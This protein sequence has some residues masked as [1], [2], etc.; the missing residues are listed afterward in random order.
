MLVLSNGENINPEELEAY[1]G[2]NPFVKEIAVLTVRDS[3][4][5][6][7]LTRLVG[8][9]VPDE[10]CFRE[11]GELHIRKRLRWE[12]ENYSAKLPTYKRIRGFVISQEALP[13]TRLGKLKRFEL[14]KIYHRLHTGGEKEQVPKPDV[15]YSDFSRSAIQFIEG[16]IGRGVSPDDHLELDLGMDSLGR[17][18]D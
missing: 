14:G 7:D 5:T 11:E 13:R 4:K 1:Y 17:L 12:L 8:I 16:Q 6:V 10:E 9:I 15:V 2:Q 3:K 18:L